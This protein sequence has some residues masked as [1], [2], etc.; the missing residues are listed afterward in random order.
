[1]VQLVSLQVVLM[2]MVFDTFLG[3]C[4]VFHEGHAVTSRKFARV[5]Y[6]GFVYMISISAGYFL[7]T[8]MPIALAQT[9]MIGF[10]AATEFISI[11]EKMGRLG[12]ETPKKLLNQ[13]KDFQSQ[14]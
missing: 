5:V 12:F 7:D 2:L 1:M 10:I 9:T 14:K 4:A 8:T 3:V 11:L 6:K 13:L